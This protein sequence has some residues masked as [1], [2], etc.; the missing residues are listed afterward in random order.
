MLIA[1]GRI[2]D[3]VNRLEAVKV[4]DTSTQNYQ[5]VSYKKLKLAI[6]KG[7]TVKG[8]KIRESISLRGAVEK[9]SNNCWR[10]NR[11]PLINGS[12]Q[13]VNEADAENIVVFGWRGFA[14]AKEYYGVDYRGKVIAIKT[15]ELLER[16]KKSKVNG[17]CINSVGTISLSSELDNEL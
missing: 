2:N 9:E 15:D 6:R 5:I 1:I 7:Y 17:A 4:F 8:F 14:E 12:G 16:I 11:I 13:L 10:F 3:T